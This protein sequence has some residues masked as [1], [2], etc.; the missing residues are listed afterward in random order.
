MRWRVCVV[1]LFCLVMVGLFV[2]SK[3]SSGESSYH[4][5]SLRLAELVA[6]NSKNLD[7]TFDKVKMFSDSLLTVTRETVE[8]KRL[9]HRLSE[10]DSAIIKLLEAQSTLDKL[11]QERI[12]LA[13]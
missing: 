1:V 6:K 4:Q 2:T 7:E 13:P 10:N 9:V 11:Q 5:D 3:S 12:D 8:Q